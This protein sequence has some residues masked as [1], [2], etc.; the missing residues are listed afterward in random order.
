[1]NHKVFREHVCHPSPLP[2]HQYR[3]QIWGTCG[4]DI[5]TVCFVYYGVRGWLFDPCG[6]I[7]IEKW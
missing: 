2:T 4:I 5:P 3:I 6:M 7:L 1:M